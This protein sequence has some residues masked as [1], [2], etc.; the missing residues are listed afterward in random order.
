MNQDES[1]GV[2]GNS[3]CVASMPPTRRRKGASVVEFAVVLP[4]IVVM[5]LGSLEMGQAVMV[6]HVLEEAARAG[7]RVA[8]FENGTKQDVLDIV[9]AAMDAANMDGYTVT[10]NPDP[11]ENLEAFQA[12]TVS[13]SI[14]Y[15]DISW[16]PT[17]DLLADASIQGICVMP[18]EGDGANDPE[19]ES[20]TAKKNKKE[21]KKESKKDVA[22]KESKKDVAKKES[23]KDV[24]KK[25]S[26]K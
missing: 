16:L 13:I 17:S 6:R 1:T 18:A 22:K 3:T 20:P 23:K 24:A 2:V 8:V 4:V 11:P 15:A 9:G 5:L 10:V 12:V 25:E 7:C 26:K 14:N 19:S 21:S